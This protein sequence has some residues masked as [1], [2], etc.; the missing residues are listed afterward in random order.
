MDTKGAIK[1]A[2]HEASSPVVAVMEDPVGS[3]KAARSAAAV[4]AAGAATVVAFAAAGASAV[5]AAGASGA[6]HDMYGRGRRLRRRRKRVSQLAVSTY[7]GS[8]LT[9]L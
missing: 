7:L 1:V 6:V 2:I 5:A 3:A 8:A 4:A 9:R